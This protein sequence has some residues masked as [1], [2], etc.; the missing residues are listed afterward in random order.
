MENKIWEKL[1]IIIVIIFSILI[2]LGFIYHNNREMLSLLS[3][4]FYFAL[5]SYVIF[6]F[7]FLIHTILNNKA[8]ME[9]IEI[10]LVIGFISGNLILIFLCIF[11]ANTSIFNVSELGLVLPIIGI[12]LV[13]FNA[14]IITILFTIRTKNLKKKYLS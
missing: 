2:P 9:K 12:V 4:I 14:L 7:I 3:S 10:N 8:E 1:L 6:V 13:L 5:Y 11:L